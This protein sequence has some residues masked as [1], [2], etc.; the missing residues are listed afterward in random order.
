VALSAED[1]L[2]GPDLTLISATATTKGKSK[3]AVITTNALEYLHKEES[4]VYALLRVQ[5][6]LT[7]VEMQV[8]LPLTQSLLAS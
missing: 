6:D 4:I 8:A 7:A 2:A 1:Q 5:S 3:A